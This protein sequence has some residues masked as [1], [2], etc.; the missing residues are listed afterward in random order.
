[1]L[2]TTSAVAVMPSWM[3]GAMLVPARK[4][5]RRAQTRAV[6]ELQSAAAEEDH[7]ENQQ[8]QHQ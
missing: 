3:V 1:M 2:L 8:K 7:R 5:P 4:N 6:R